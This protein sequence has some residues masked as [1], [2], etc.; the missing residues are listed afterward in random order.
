M[1]TVINIFAILVGSG[2]GVLL[3][4]RLPQKMSRTLTDAM[5][6]VVLVIGALNLSALQDEAFTQTVGTSGTLLVV[7]GAL[8]M[9]GV[10]G[11][12]LKIEERL[13]EFGSWL[14]HKTSRGE[15]KDKERFI[16]GFVNS[17]LLFTIGPMAV[18]GSL[19]D[20][21]G[22]GIEV[23]ALK[24]TLD[25]F[26]AIAFAA[27]LGWGVAFSFIP[28]GLWQGLLTLAA[29]GA[30]AVMSDAVIASITAT[31]GVLLLGTALRLMQIRMVSV[32]DLLPA[33]LF[34]PLLTVLVGVIL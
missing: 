12:L 1:G 24:S 15:S 21:L 19:Q 22:Q 26:T 7:L 3:G 29:L 25:G 8:L 2:L 18:L 4:H 16:E 17:S 27:A 13:S 33:L 31:G 10:F 5:G 32:A 6:L 34:A 20:G 9:G 14:Q 30:G 11:S 23:L 28:V